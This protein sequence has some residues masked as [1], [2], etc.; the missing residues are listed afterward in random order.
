MCACLAVLDK[1]FIASVQ[2]QVRAKTVLNCLCEE[3]L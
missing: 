3:T 1:G 2:G